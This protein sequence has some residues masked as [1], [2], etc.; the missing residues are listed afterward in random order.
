M[1]DPAKVLAGFKP[2]GG[3]RVIAARVHGVLKSAFSEPPPLQGDQKRPDN[4]PAHKAQTDGPANMVVV[5]DPTYWPTGSG[6]GWRISWGSRLRRRS[7]T[8]GRSWPTWSEP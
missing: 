4:F 7:P 2:E 8:T 3:P 1:P 5:A 6:F